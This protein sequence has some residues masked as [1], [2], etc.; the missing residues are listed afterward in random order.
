[1]SIQ[2]FEVGPRMSQVVV[3]GNTVYLAGVVAQKTAGESVT[4]QTEEILSIIDGHL[5]KAGTD[6][7]KLLSA[8][9]Y[10]T[11]IKT[12]GEMNAVWDGWVSAGNTPAR[13]TVEAG[14]AAPQYT[15]EIMVIAAK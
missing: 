15:V 1:M 12:F 10:L 8:T 11:D 6:K 13:A 7:T 5:A 4:K 9:I 14:L 3:H 2:R